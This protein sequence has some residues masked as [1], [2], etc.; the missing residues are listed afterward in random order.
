[1]SMASSRIILHHRF[2]RRAED[3]SPDIAVALHAIGQR[4]AFYGAGIAVDFKSVAVV[5][6][7]QRN[8]VAAGGMVA[9]ICGDVADAEAA[10]C[11]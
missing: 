3:V 5:L 4:M 6:A 7:Q 10:G 11:G 9:E 8:D 1:M 2:I